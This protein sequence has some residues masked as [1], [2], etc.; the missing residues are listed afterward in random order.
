MIMKIVGKHDTAV[1]TFNNHYDRVRNNIRVMD[2][3][4]QTSCAYRYVFPFQ[5]VDPQYLP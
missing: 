1:N 5:N 2:M 4:P 3:V